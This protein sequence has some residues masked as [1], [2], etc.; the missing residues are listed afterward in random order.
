MTVSILH[1]LT[2]KNI[3]YFEREDAD[4]DA[5]GLGEGGPCVLL[6]AV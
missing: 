5:D 2:N 1:R 3:A 6:T 4:A